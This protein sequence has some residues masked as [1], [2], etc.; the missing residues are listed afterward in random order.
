MDIGRALMYAFEDAD[1]MKKILIG[2]LLRFV[3]IVGLISD[4]YG[5]VQTKNVYEGREL[6]LP[7][8]DNF[9]GYFTK[10]LMMFVGQFIYAIP[11]ILIYC[12]AFILP[13]F[14]VG[15]GSS[16][17]SSGAA[18]AGPLAALATPLLLCGI[19]LLLLYALALLVFLP[20]LT[21]RYA[22]TEQFAA[23]FQIGPAWQMISSNLGGYAMAI[24]VLIIAALIG[25]FVGSIPCGLGVPFAGFWTSLVSAYLFG[26]FAKGAPQTSPA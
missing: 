8:W 18:Q 16:S 6:P 1:K 7:E 9:G 11:A 14:L 20:A 21:T 3:P 25:G 22:I 4:G 26:N 19:C 10:G 23:F 2:G 13:T 24:L 5:L 17:S 12:C 15:A